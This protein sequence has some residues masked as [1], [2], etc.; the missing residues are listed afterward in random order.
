V[1]NIIN[2]PKPSKLRSSHNAFSQ[3]SIE[4]S[5]SKTFQSE[6][7][8]CFG[9]RYPYTKNNLFFGDPSILPKTIF[10]CLD[11]I[12]NLLSTLPDIPKDHKFV[13]IIGDTDHTFPQ[14]VDAR[15]SINFLDA[16]EQLISDNRILHIFCV[17]LDIPKNERIS[18]LPVGFDFKWIDPN[19]DIEYDIDINSKLFKIFD[20]SRIRGGDQWADREQAKTFCCKYWSDFCDSFSETSPLE[21]SENLSKYA[22]VLC[23]HGGGLEPNPKVFHSLLYGSI[24]IVKQFVNCEILYIDLP[25]AFIPDWKPEHITAEKLKIWIES[26]QDYFYNKE[27][28]QGVL[29]KLTTDYW[30]EYI[31]KESKADFKLFS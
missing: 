22:F 10:V 28:R 17:H 12:N 4:G 6:C 24:P 20:C 21:F 29:N 19:F 18:P 13:L 2:T 5:I 7:C 11:N 8:W 3:V 16:Y 9:A 14:Q 25:V 27:K 30:K 26:F 15:Y 1:N 23:P 31:Q